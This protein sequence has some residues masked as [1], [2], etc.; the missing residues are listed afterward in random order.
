M[1]EMVKK[2]LECR[3]I[4]LFVDIHGHSRQKNL[5]IY[6]CQHN[7]V[8]LA[9]NPRGPPNATP[10]THKEKVLPVMFSKTADWFSFS[11]CAFGVQKCK[12]STGRVV[13]HREFGVTNAYTLEASFCGPTQGSFKDSHFS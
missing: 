2:T 12:E 5:F 4:H 9:K 3:D 7:T 8:A 11:D 6:G 13:M 10:M 1:K